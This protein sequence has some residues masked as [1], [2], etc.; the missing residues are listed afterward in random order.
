M[1]ENKEILILAV[2]ALIA[3]IGIILMIKF[4]STGLGMYGGS[5]YPGRAV[6]K[7]TLDRFIKGGSPEGVVVGTQTRGGYLSYMGMSQCPE[8]YR[9]ISKSLYLNKL[10]Y[11]RDI[12]IQTKYPE[13]YPGQMC[14]PSTFSFR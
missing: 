1:A 2:I 6:E 7:S 13:D 5:L 14:C 11:Y 12:C 10:D 3:V 4:S 9:P 8:N